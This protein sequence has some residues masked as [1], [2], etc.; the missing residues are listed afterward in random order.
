MIGLVKIAVNG[1]IELVYPISCLGCGYPCGELICAECREGLELIK[2]SLCL[3]CGKPTIRPVDEC[4]ECSGKR[5]PF[6]ILRSVG[7]HAGP[8]REVVHNL[9]YGNGIR[10][11]R[12]LSGFMVELINRSGF[13]AEFIT[14]VPVH[15]K[16]MGER[17]YNQALLLALQLSSKISKPVIDTMV[18]IRHTV[19]QNS[20]PLKE[21]GTNLK[22]AFLLKKN[23][24][25][26]GKNVI[27]I[28]D[29]YTS[30]A[31]IKEA[32]RVLK[33]AGASKIIA[34]TVTR[35]I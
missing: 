29:V 26:K 19:E 28:D 32:S 6:D 17:G 1:I 21:R 22:R 5:L 12:L 16:T 10:S 8:L 18:K 34:V 35:A 9:K 27:L 33:K 31:T 25:I 15:R 24:D 13:E 4:R 2:D 11:A 30:G 14:F 3:K 20:L 7:V 23:I